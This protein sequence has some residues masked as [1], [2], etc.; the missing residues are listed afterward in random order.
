MDEVVAGGFTIG[1]AMVQATP[2]VD[3]RLKVGGMT[4]AVL[5]KLKPL[6]GKTYLTEAKCDEALKAV[7]GDEDFARYRDAVIAQARLPNDGGGP[8]TMSQLLL[9]R[10]CAARESRA[11]Q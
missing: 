11:A 4:G 10:A 5:T 3:R 2:H 1:Q 6:I 9:G 7:L 8:D